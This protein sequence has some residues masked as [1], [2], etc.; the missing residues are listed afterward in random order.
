MVR[1]SLSSLVPRVCAKGF[2]HTGIRKQTTA[3]TGACL[4]ISEFRSPWQGPYFPVLRQ[5][6]GRKHLSPHPCSET[7]VQVPELAWTCKIF[8]VHGQDLTSPSC[9]QG[10]GE[11]ICPHK[12]FW[13]NDHRR[14]SLPGHVKISEP[15]TGTSLSCLVPKTWPKAFVPTPVFKNKSPGAAACLDMWNLLSPW[16]GLH[17]LVL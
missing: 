3:G 16:S 2:A 6:V 14:R 12:H 7:K 1:T 9:V 17:F 11:K 8:L 15:M 4:N 13:K 10:L 5:R